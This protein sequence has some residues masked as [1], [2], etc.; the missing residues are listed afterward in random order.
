MKK[1][2]LFQ[3]VFFILLFCIREFFY[4][5]DV[6][7]EILRIILLLGLSFFFCRN[8]LKSEKMFQTSF[9]IALI[10]FLLFQISLFLE[11]L[12]GYR[13]HYGDVPVIISASLALVGAISYLSILFLLCLLWRRIK[14]ST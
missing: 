7:K 11:Y 13:P 9:K 10:F 8:I 12:L 5:Q 6:I 1:I 3:G 14:K 4:Y 2:I